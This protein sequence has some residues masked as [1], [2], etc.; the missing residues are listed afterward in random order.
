MD[1]AGWIAAMDAGDLIAGYAA[2][3]GTGALVWEVVRWRGDRKVRLKVQ[4]RST[5]P[6]EKDWVLLIEV[7]NLSAFPVRVTSIRIRQDKAG[8]QQ[9]GRTSIGARGPDLPGEIPARDARTLELT[10]GELTT[11]MLDPLAPLAVEVTLAT[12]ETVVE[13]PHRLGDE[14]PSSVLPL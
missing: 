5:P 11:V 10:S 12:G 1:I 9:N 14:F 8:P 3:V 7:I 13:G 4:L 2:L 6:N